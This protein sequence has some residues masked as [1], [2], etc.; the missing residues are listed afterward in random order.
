MLHGFVCFAFLKQS[1]DLEIL[2]LELP[3]SYQISAFWNTD[4]QH[5]GRALK[6]PHSTY[7]DPSLDDGKNGARNRQHPTLQ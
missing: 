6:A 4:V 5:R 7:E 2:S 3:S 1:Y